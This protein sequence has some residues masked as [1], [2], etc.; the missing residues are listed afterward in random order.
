MRI[1]LENVR[2]TTTLVQSTTV[3]LR[4]DGLFNYHVSRRQKRPTDDSV[5][6]EME[7]PLLGVLIVSH[8]HET[9][10]ESLN[11]LNLNLYNR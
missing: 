1:Q 11:N 5:P 4:P 2:D 6:P 7:K 8:V 3:V 10:S 9:L